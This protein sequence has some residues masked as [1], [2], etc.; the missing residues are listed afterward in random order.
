ML[1]RL[2]RS[3]RLKY[4]KVTFRKYREFEDW[5]LRNCKENSILWSFTNEMGPHTG[6]FLPKRMM[7]LLYPC[8][9]RGHAM[10][11]D[12]PMGVSFSHVGRPIAQSVDR[13]GD[14]VYI[15][16]FDT[17]DEAHKAWWKFRAKEILAILE[18]SDIPEE[19]ANHIREFCDEKMG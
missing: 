7:T 11:M 9:K 18:D 17:V 12:V 3:V 2:W 1:Y 10:R 15:G 19:A 5:Y 13:D 8:P 4:S 6:V 14:M 16:V